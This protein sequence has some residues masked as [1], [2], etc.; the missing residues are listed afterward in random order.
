M[1]EEESENEFD[2]DDSQSMSFDTDTDDYEMNLLDSQS[3]DFPLFNEVRSI[4]NTYSAFLYKYPASINTACTCITLQ[5]P[6]A[7]L[8]QSLQAVFG[9]LVDDIILDVSIELDNL[10]WDSPPKNIRVEHPLFHKKYVGQVLIES[11]IQRFFS[12]KFKPK[13][14]YKSEMFI[15]SPSGQPDENKLETL[16]KEGYDKAKARDALVLCKNNV[17]LAKNFLRTG[18][19]INCESQIL[20]SYNQCPLLYFTLELVECF[21]DLQDHCCICRKPLQTVG[22]KPTTCDDKFCEFQYSDLGIGNSL[23]VEIRR[24]PLVADLLVSLFSMALDTQYLTPAPPQSINLK[25][26]K[27]I[28]S[29]LPPMDEIAKCESDENIMKLIS[30][31]AYNLLKWII[32]SNRSHLITVPSHLKLKEFE[33]AYQFL[34]LISTPEAEVEFQKLQKKNGSV[35]LFHGSEI[36]KWHSIFRNGLKNYSGTPMQA[37]GAAL[38]PGI[39]FS[40]SS[41]ISLSY[42]TKF[43]RNINNINKY[44]N[45]E[46]KSLTILALCQV[47]KVD[48]LIDYDWA[49]TLTNE[50]ACIIRFLLVN[51]NNSVDII[52]NPPNVPLLSDILNYQASLVSKK[53]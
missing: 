48:E 23:I 39:Y 31:S 44:Q 3:I 40:K 38:G 42:S 22:L 10:K 2:A 35:Y 17:N 8:P 1:S 11:T 19:M 33:S 26:C 16:V 52:K 32:F 5:I 25:E 7:F 24:D 49:H 37:N 15:L 45:S 29:D 53:K 43:E 51:C 14:I 34:S 41:S 21:F 30:S 46:F 20:V 28:I 4:V 9:F 27:K 6:R 50:K 13:A 47:A 18:E 12:D 36:S